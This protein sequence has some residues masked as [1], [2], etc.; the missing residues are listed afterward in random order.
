M[1]NNAARRASMILGG[2]MIVAIA[3]SAI[4]PIFT[5]SATTAQQTAQA[6]DAPTVTSPPVVTDFSTIKFDT[7]YLHPSGLFSVAVPTGWIPGQATT[8][9]DGVE[10]TMNNGS[11][12]SVIQS[13][14][15]IAQAA[16]PDLDAVDSLYSDTTLNASWTNYARVYPNPK[17]GLLSS[18]NYLETSR[19]REDN[20]VVIDFELKN[21]RGQVFVARQVAW[22][23]QDWVY[24]LRVVTPDNQID[25]LK[26]L[27]DN[28]IQSFKPNRIFAGTPADWSAYFDPSN[29]LIVRFPA[30]WRVTDSAAG[31][32]T[33]IDGSAGSLRVQS[34]SV[35]A[36][37][38]EA[39]ARNWVSANV[40]GAT[41][42]SAKA[43]A[44]G[45]LSGFTVAYTYADAD[46]NSNSGLALLLNGANNT[47][48]SANLRIFESNVDLNVD[49]AQV[50]HSD[51]MK[52]L[53][54]FQLLPGIKVPL[55][56]PT[57]TFT[58]PPPTSTSE[59]TATPTATETPLPTNPATVTN[60]PVPPTATPVPTD[61][62]VPPTSTPV[63]PTSTPKPT[64][65]VVPPTATTVPTTEATAESTPA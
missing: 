58:L 18:M 38:D 30:T 37:L 20:K 39:A 4:L 57:P 50:T 52:I 51:L 24:S 13:S 31:R 26:Y 7:D 14:V 45:E 29:N 35:S 23:D 56:T 15:Q 48:Y 44:R 27:M 32:P 22:A 63:P 60:T 53:N 36:A 61:T 17:T 41:V 5:N 19:T 33:T 46:G 2:V 47:L 25:L 34:Q 21:A 28:L 62:P 8:K 55:P 6:T 11:I 10:I 40:N 64:D 16:I 43:A 1:D 9:A 54:S 12:L 42:T 59:F 3:L 49:T 65:T